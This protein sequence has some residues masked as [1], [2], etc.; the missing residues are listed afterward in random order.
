MRHD[1]THMDETGR[2]F[3]VME[4]LPPVSVR[5]E[6][7]GCPAY[8]INI[9]RLF[10]ATRSGCGKRDEGDIVARLRPYGGLGHALAYLP[11]E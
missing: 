1:V 2:L 9:C 8:I 4:Y 3:A 5:T 11:N 7:R 10:R 6:D